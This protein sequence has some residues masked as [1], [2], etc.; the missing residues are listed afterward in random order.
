MIERRRIV[1]W[2][3]WGVVV[4][5]VGVAVGALGQQVERQVVPAV[6]QSVEVGENVTVF[7]RTTDAEGVGE[8]PV[9]APQVWL[10]QHLGSGTEVR[11]WDW[12][13]EQFVSYASDVPPE[14]QATLYK[15]AS[16]L[17]ARNLSFPGEAGHFTLVANAEFDTPTGTDVVTDARSI[18]VHGSMLVPTIQIALLAT[19]TVLSFWNGWV[20][21]GLFPW[22][23]LLGSQFNS[24]EML[25]WTF[26]VAGFALGIGLELVAHRFALGRR[27]R[28]AVDR[29]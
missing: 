25:N 13:D 10:Y 1:W 23:A 2:V 22:L 29:D 7:V 28:A 26:G 27:I 20:F 21:A 12:T 17:F 6:N 11:C 8:E 15:R 9:G 24:P 18:E 3:V 19:G 16:A 4:V 5:V 14:C